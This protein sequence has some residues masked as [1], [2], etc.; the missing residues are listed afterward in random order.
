MTSRWARFARGWSVALFS[1][2]VAALSHT[3]GGGAAPSA[4]AVIVSLAFAGMICVGLTGRTVSKLRLVL[5][6]VFSQVIFHVLFSFGGAGGALITDATVTAD[7]HTHLGVTVGL[8]PTGLTETVGS[9]AGHPGHAG[10]A[11]WLAHLAAAL[12]TVIALRH[13]DR[14]VA[15]ALA[16]ARLGI[17]SISRLREVRRIPV[18]VP[19]EL[20][21]TPMT[22]DAPVPH[23]LGIFLVTRP[24]R[25]PPV[26]ALCA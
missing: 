26:Y 21:C 11:M 1:T 24:H 18:A 7:P 2:L 25:G 12:I 6:V 8:M 10:A 9:T 15:R 22:A 19:A 14:A 23:D 4:L 16:T 17:R 13:G 20:R 5:S 3:L